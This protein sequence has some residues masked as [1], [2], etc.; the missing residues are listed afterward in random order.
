LENLFDLFDQNLE[1][2]DSYSGG[3]AVFIVGAFEAVSVAWFYG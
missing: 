1:I 3:W 2:I